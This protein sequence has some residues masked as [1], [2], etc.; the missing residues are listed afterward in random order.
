MKARFAA[1]RS[2]LAR[3]VISPLGWGVAC[4]GAVAWLVARRSGWEE[5]AVLAAACA[6]ALV[7]AVAFTF[8]RPKLKVTLELRP[9][10][11]TMG[12]PA[13]AQVVARSVAARRMLPLRLEVV[14]GAGVAALDVPSLAPDASHDELLIVPTNRRAVVPV[15]PVRSV[16]GD[17]LG[18]LRREVTWTGVEEL[19]VEELYVHPRIVLVGPLTTGHL[20]DLEGETTNDRSPSDVAFHTLREYV[21]GDDRRHIHWRTTAR[22]IDGKLMVREFVDTRRTHVG[23]LL[24][25]RPDDYA[26]AAE[27]ELAVSVYG[28]LGARALADEQV[29]SCVAGTTRIPSHDRGRLL[30][31]LSGVELGGDLAELR[32]ATGRCRDLMAGASVIVL[33][34]G[35]GTSP[36]AM[37]LATEVFGTNARILA[38]RAV[39][40]QQAGIR[41]M[42]NAS[43]LDVA[44]LE[45]LPRLMWSVAS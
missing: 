19:G 36:E 5:F 24:S 34:A 22:Q 40:G 6:V 37:R 9:R 1:L 45:D 12:E 25:L 11:V 21:P 44:S 38:V 31:S 43:F 10:R 13:S 42:G 41:R 39:S 3:S 35:S 27:F 28:S 29:I 17:P 7:V 26:D 18:L 16:R 8:G 4:L 14:V 23:M 20:R 30:D 15:G 32:T 33:V 2:R